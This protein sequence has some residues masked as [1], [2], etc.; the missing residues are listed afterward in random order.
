MSKKKYNFGG[1]VFEAETDI[2]LLTVPKYEEFRAGD[3]AESDFIIRIDP[4]PE[5]SVIGRTCPAELK[6]DGNLIEVSMNRADIPNISIA[7]LL[8]TAG[9]AYLFPEKDAFILHASYVIREGRALLFTAPSRT[10]KSTQARFWHEKRGV[11]VVNGDRVLITCREGEFFANGIY[12]SGKS[13]LCRNMTTPIGQIVL[14]EQGEKNEIRRI[15]AVELFMRI[16]CQCSFDTESDMQREKITALIA[17]MMNRVPVC[18]FSCRY[19]D[20]SVDDLERFLWM[21]K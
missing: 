5:D 1:V 21:K 15:R 13:G 6:R 14:L 9:A 4:L 20:E 16:L 3:S 8:F 10:G 2:P 12:S 7:N 18:C 11:E 19:G 17:D